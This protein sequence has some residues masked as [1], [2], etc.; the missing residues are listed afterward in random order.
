MLQIHDQTS[1]VGKGS[2][3]LKTKNTQL[4]KMSVLCLVWVRGDALFYITYECCHVGAL[5]TA[6][7]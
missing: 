3:Q 2:S 6:A 5:L 1:G 4:Q 7:M